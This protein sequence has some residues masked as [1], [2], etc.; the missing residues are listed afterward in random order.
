[1]TLAAAVEARGVGE[2]LGLKES[3]DSELER[4]AAA[5]AIALKR[6]IGTS[7]YAA[8]LAQTLDSNVEYLAL[9]AGRLLGAAAYYQTRVPPVGT[10]GVQFSIQRGEA[11][12]E[13]FA[14]PETVGVSAAAL[15]NQAEMLLRDAGLYQEPSLYVGTVIGAD[16]DDVAP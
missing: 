4:F 16:E 13:S 6:M 10:R 3:Q 1:M 14:T 15:K 12:S 7:N 5:G 2:T 11:A 8:L 9:L